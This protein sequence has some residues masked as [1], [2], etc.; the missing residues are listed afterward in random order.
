MD[1]IDELMKAF[2]SRNKAEYG[3][4]DELPGGFVE[5]VA[6]WTAAGEW[7]NHPQVKAWRRRGRLLG[8]N[9]RGHRIWTGSE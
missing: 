3:T 8:W 9:R 2:G 6:N 7:Q 5:S 1:E 4:G